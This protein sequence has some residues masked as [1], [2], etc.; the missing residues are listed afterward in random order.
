MAPVATVSSGPV[1]T[2]ASCKCVRAQSSLGGTCSKVTNPVLRNDP[3]R[4]IR[5]ELNRCTQR[6]ATVLPNIF[7]NKAVDTVKGAQD[8][9][10]SVV[11]E[12][13]I[14]NVADR[15][16]RVPENILLFRRVVSVSD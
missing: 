9:I 2:I 8:K 16:G 11:G 14:L 6:Y 13:H 10:R 12:G 1:G 5:V 3:F 7:R 15:R 4:S